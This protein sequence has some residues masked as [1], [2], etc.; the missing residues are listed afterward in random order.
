MKIVHVDPRDVGLPRSLWLY[1]Y[2]AE[3]FIFSPEPQPIALDVLTS[4]GFQQLDMAGIGELG[5]SILEGQLAD[6]ATV[7]DDI[8][9][10][11]DTL[12]HAERVPIILAFRPTND[13]LQFFRVS[14]PLPEFRKHYV[15]HELPPPSLGEVALLWDGDTWVTLESSVLDTAGREVCDAIH[16]LIL[17]MAAPLTQWLPPTPAVMRAASTGFSFEQ[18]VRAHTQFIADIAEDADYAQSF[19]DD[20]AQAHRYVETMRSWL[21]QRDVPR[22]QAQWRR[23]RL[24]ARQLADGYWQAYTLQH[25]PRAITHPAAPTVTIPYG[26]VTGSIMR[27]LLN[28]EEYR[29]APPQA[30]WTDGQMTIAVQPGDG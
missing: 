14:S 26:Q 15:A 2:Q 23:L 8:W 27:A 18:L 17:E 13:Q 22:Y 9:V 4:R 21:A 11:E 7:S 19:A 10:T 20:L 30:T 1:Q 5:L 3:L 28:R 6:L 25:L 12:R 16:D 24:L 29:Q